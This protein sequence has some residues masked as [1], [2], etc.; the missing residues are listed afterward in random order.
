MPRSKRLKDPRP[1]W[2]HLTLEALRV[3]DDFVSF[4]DLR[5]ATGASP[6]Q[7]SAALFHLQKRRCVEAIEGNGKLWWFATGEDTRSRVQELR[8]PE[9][10]GSRRRGPR[11]PRSGPD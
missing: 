7:L 1:T 5:A 8:T 9:E 3:A 2:T 4:D 10:P 11:R 6:N